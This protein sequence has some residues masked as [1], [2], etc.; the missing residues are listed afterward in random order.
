[1]DETYNINAI[2]LSRFDFRENDARIEVFS[3]EKGKLNLVVRGAKK[4][5]SKLAGHIEPLN[6]V[7]IMVVR[8]RQF[9]YAGAVVSRNCYFNLK[10]NLSKIYCAGLVVK[11]INKAIREKDNTDA[12]YFFNLIKDFLFFLNNDAD[13]KDYGLFFYFFVLK[14]L[15]ELGYMPELKNCLICKEKIKSEKSSFDFL[16]GGIVCRKCSL[17]IPTHISRDRL[18]ISSDCIKVL[19]TIINNDFKILSKININKNLSLE[20]I[21]II[22]VLEKYNM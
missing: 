11:Y 4:G 7:D 8:G 19:S 12:V 10:D 15:S 13:H 21:K 1:M 9:D 17:S 16:L 22:S 14:I 6:L 20:I 2:I 3:A 18:T 5:K